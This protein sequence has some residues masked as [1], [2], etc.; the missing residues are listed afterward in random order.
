MK[1]KCLT[2]TAFNILCISCFKLCTLVPRSICLSFRSLFIMSNFR[3]IFIRLIAIYLL[4]VFK[5]YTKLVYLIFY[6]IFCLYRVVFGLGTC[7]SSYNNTC[8][9]IVELLC[10][11]LLIHPLSFFIY[12]CFYRFLTWLPARSHYAVLMVDSNMLLSYNIELIG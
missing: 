2:Y 1:K 11:I 10:L 8:C 4:I 6:P 5:V 12:V 3:L 9:F 7:I